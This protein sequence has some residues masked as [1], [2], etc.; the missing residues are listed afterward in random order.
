M[1]WATLGQCE[2]GLG[3]E[4]EG[5]AIRPHLLPKHAKATNLSGWLGMS[6]QCQGAG[7][8]SALTTEG[9][10]VPEARED[11]AQGLLNTWCY[12]SCDGNTTAYFS[13]QENRESLDRRTLAAPLGSP[14]PLLLQKLLATLHLVF[15][16]FCL[17]SSE[18]LWNP[19]PCPCPTLV[20]I[21]S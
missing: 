8:P 19:T 15:W 7:G 11:S 10:I 1:H 17:I 2:E 21:K 4:G 18:P 16:T 12:W 13:R 14:T 20:H 6:S 3:K 5:Q 9:G